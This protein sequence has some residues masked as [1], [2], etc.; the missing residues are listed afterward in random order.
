LQHLLER[1]A[2]ERGSVDVLSLLMRYTV[3]VTS[4]VGFGKDL[5]T[6]QQGPDSLQR[7][8]EHIFPAVQQ[9]VIAPFPYW[10]LLPSARRVENAV[11]ATRQILLGLISAARGTLEREPER[12]Q[13][14]QTLL[15]AMLAAQD[16]ERGGAR[17]TDDEVFSNVMTLLLAGEDTTANTLSWMMHYLAL[18]PQVQA[19][20][21]QEVDAVLGPQLMPTLAHLKQLPYVAG[22]AQEALRLRSP[23]PL[24]YL[25]ATE[26]TVVEQIAV[27]RGTA[28]LAL[29]RLPCL[30]N[31]LFGDAENFRPERWLPEPPAD[32]QPHSPRLMMPFGAGPRVCPGRSLALLECALVTGMVLRHFELEVADPSAPVS[33]LNAFTV[34]PDGIRLRF[35]RRASA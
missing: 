10:R 23:A 9:R 33:E 26:D 2:Q 14:P 4:I 22:V 21:R 35:R 34:Q 17:L 12:A 13:R 30:D 8:I 7:H 16:E 11:S 19:R 15:D 31:A 32:T 20:A 25:E 24:L 5:D 18:L 29:T 6:L 28:V 3:D 27:P 1:A